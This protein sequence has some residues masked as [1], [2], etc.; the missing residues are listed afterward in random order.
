MEAAQ[1]LRL[2]PPQV[3]MRDGAVVIDGLVVTDERLVELVQRRIEQDQSPEE[4]VVQALEI[5]ARVLDREST[6]AEVDFVKLELEKIAATVERSFGERADAVAT[7]LQRQMEEAFGEEGGAVAAALDG[8]AEQMAD[9]IATTFGADRSSAVQNQIKELV[10]RSL[11]ESQ[12]ALVRAFSSADGQNPLADLKAAVVRELKS[13]QESDRALLEKVVALEGE[14]K[15]LHDAGEAQAELEAER[16]RGAAKG[17]AFEDVVFEQIQAIA[18]ARGDAAHHTGDE[19]SES[20]DKVGDVVVE[21]DAASR[22]A[23][24]RMV[25]EAKDKRLSRADA[26]RELDAAL[27][28]RDAQFAVLVVSSDQ[29]VPARTEPLAEYQGNKMIVTL[30]K[31]ELDP[32]GLELAYR[33]ARCRLLVER[34]AAAAVDAAGVR[35]ATE[36]A[37]AALRDAQKIRL[38]L[39]KASD[40]VDEARDVL[41]A[42]IA[43][44]ETAL[45]RVE[46]L[47]GP[48]ADA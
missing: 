14:V 47:I 27:E 7:V 35:A 8:H 9:Q 5:G 39:T 20:G 43:R 15:R 24:G 17:R 16:E 31:D 19:Q 40:G 42:M 6:A 34:D 10:E 26:W 36:E 33:Y 12:Q 25:F 46:A 2:H 30:D 41:N 38:H 11:R 29:K 44:V 1:T 45:A 23:R 48:D 3:E 13:G 37:A 18:D 21:L 22:G 4:A 32:R 28:A